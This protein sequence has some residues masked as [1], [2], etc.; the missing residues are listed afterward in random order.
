[1]VGELAAGQRNIDPFRH[2]FFFHPEI[3]EKAT[4]HAPCQ[5]CNESPYLDTIQ[6]I[7]TSRMR[8]CSPKDGARTRMRNACTCMH[9]C[10]QKGRAPVDQGK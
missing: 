6:T 1:V 7:G 2:L 4:N 8:R 5:V 10:A 3:G 9:A